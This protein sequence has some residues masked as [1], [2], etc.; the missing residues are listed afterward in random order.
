MPVRLFV[1][2]LA[3]SVTEVDLRRHFGVCGSVI[4]VVIVFDADARQQAD[5]GFIEMADENSTRAALSMLNGGDLRGRRLS[6]VEAR[7]RAIWLGPKL[8]EGE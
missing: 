1:G 6:V 3:P 7:P 8:V 5:W 4:S 2:G